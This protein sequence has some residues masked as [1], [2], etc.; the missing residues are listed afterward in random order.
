MTY[1][2]ERLRVPWDWWLRATVGVVIVWWVFAVSTTL[3]F[4]AVM[5]LVT[6]ALMIA[7]LGSYG[8]IEL[9]VT[10]DTF[11]AGQATIEREFC[12]K[13]QV[14]DADD[15][16]WRTGPGADARAHL[17]IRPYLQQ[18]VLVEIDDP[19]DPTPYWLVSSRNPH[20]LAAALRTT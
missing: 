1:Y 12:A 5:A 16:R 4:A 19:A 15:F 3:L 6:S 10:A 18:G 14:V 7:A 20:G 2:H 17:V 9:T 11:V 8:S 13:A